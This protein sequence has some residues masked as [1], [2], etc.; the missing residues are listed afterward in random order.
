MNQKFEHESLVRERLR[1]SA[2]LK[3]ALSIDSEYVSNVAAVA[4]AIVRTFQRKGRLF[5]FGNGG[6]A[7][8]AQHIAAEFAGRYLL[9]R[10]PWPAMA[11]TANTS[12]L[13]AIGNDYGFERIFER[14]IEGLA[15]EG[16]VAIGLSTSG[17][18]ANV[19]RGLE[20][21]RAKKLYC[22]ALTG[23]NGRS[24]RLIV[25]ICLCTPSDQTPRIQEVHLL[26]GHILCEAVEKTMV[27]AVPLAAYATP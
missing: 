27:S 11:L 17:T 16:D 22:V 8:D 1:E 15:Q 26:T 2:D 20:M 5:L 10:S 6:S 19:I 21:A 7:A 25:D 18:S 3:H 4:A 12:T 23:K 24:L 14:Q 13:T 9:D